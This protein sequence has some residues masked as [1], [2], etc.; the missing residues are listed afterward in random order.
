MTRVWKPANG[1]DIDEG[2]YS[3]IDAGVISRLPDV[4]T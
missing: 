3:Y 2:K 4:H 1:P